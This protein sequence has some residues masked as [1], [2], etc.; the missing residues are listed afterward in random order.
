MATSHPTREALL[1]A[2]IRLAESKGLQQVSINDIVDA[3]GVAK[4][5]FYVHF[6]DRAALLVAIHQRFYDG[7]IDAMAAA[8]GSRPP[9]AER[10]LLGSEAYLDACLAAR[11][12]KAVLVEAR[13]D[14]AL[15]VEIGRRDRELAELA[16]P[17]FRALGFA[18]AE[19]AARLF[20]ALVATAAVV[21]LEHARR[22]DPVRATIA[23]YLRR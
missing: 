21:E 16:R 12:V 19:P 3:A 17:N 11:G 8:T 5:T 22:D 14:L 9:G 15:T 1:D 18:H 4:G 7:I 2:S 13:S 6:A 10:L 23:E 20:I